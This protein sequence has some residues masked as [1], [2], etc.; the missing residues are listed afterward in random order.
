[1]SEESDSYVREL[2]KGGGI[3]LVGLALELGLSFLA[4]I[5]V[6]Q[7]FTP[8]EYGAVS[9]GI[10]LL[11]IGSTVALLGLNTGVSRYL[12]RFDTDSRRRG[13]M[14]TAFVL[15]VPASILLAG[16]V[17]LVAPRLAGE[18]FSGPMVL[19]IL[20]VFAIGIPVEA[21]VNLTIGVSKGLK[22][23]FL[24]LLARGFTLPSVRL[25]GVVAV[26]LLGFDIVGVAGAYFLSYLVAGAVCLGYLL[27]RTSLFDRTVEWQP[28][29]REM[30]AFSLPLL[31]TFAMRH[32]FSDIDTLLL[33]AFSSTTG[34][35]GIYNVIYPLSELLTVPLQGFSFLF[36]PVISELHA[37]RDFDQ[38]NRLY[39]VVTKWIFVATFPAFA[40]FAMF[41]SR[42]IGVTFGSKYAS[43]ATAFVILASGFL[44]HTVAGLNRSSLMGIGE[45]RV[46]MWVNFATA[47]L[48]VALNLVLIPP[49]GVLGAAVATTISYL[50]LNGLA[51]GVLYRRFGV[52]P[53]T[54]ATLVPITVVT[55]ATALGYF[56][57][58]QVVSFTIVNTIL[59][60]TS[61]L[62]LYVVAV[63]RFGGIEREEIVLV[64]SI[65]ERF[66][67]DLGPLKAVAKV[68]MGWSH[69]ETED[70][71]DR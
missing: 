1:M 10:T 61:F 63:L 21:F 20:V 62:V 23:P 37:N 47:V 44:V 52:N 66:G 48:N 55:I 49:Y 57:V 45:T 68:V 12:P 11:S 53:I 64:L 50:A 58:S 31:I 27:R 54:R 41:P 51:S 24:K 25:V 67:L 39:Q 7:S 59:F 14:V 65:E 40:V 69:P 36:L 4:K 5:V 60:V 43:G 28:M 30:L 70:R 15:T 22:S 42:I 17:V 3:V 35:V 56:T 16:S 26:V 13:V 46:V 19:P 29:Y 9:I 32:V 18:V 6:A 33:G 34:P 38:M 2:F 71:E 8:E